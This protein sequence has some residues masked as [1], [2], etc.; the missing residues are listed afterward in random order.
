MGYFLSVRMSWIDR[1]D[2][3]TTLYILKPGMVYISL[4]FCDKCFSMVRMNIS[5]ENLK[6]IKYR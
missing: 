3:Y 2:D 4:K 1:G 6:E 5:K